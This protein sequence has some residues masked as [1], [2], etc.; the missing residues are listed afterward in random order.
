[1]ARAKMKDGAIVIPKSLRDAHGLED[2]AE[3]EIVDQGKLIVL[4]LV[5]PVEKKDAPKKLTLEE[6]IERIPRYEG[7]PITDEMISEAIA[8]ES[9]AGGMKRIVVARDGMGS[10]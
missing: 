10:A 2:G 6:F 9:G 1:M 4:E 3:F 7:P 5:E 8:E